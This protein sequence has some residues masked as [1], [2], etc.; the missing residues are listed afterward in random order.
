[1]ISNLEK[2]LRKSFKSSILSSS[3]SPSTMSGVLRSGWPIM[4]RSD[5]VPRLL[6]CRANEDIRKK[7]GMSRWSI[8]R[9]L[10]EDVT[11]YV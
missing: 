10:Q 5:H 7:A 4:D 2:I 6:R 11:G 3:T 8:A 9:Q 1:M